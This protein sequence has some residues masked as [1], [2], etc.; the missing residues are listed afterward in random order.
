[1]IEVKKITAIETYDIRL[2]V[3]RKNIP[4]PFEFKGD[5]DDDTFH[6]GAF[7]N[8]KLISKT[9]NSYENS[10]LVNAKLL[11]K[12]KNY[13]MKY[14]Y[15]DQDKLTKT[16]FYKKGKLKESWIYECKPEGEKFNH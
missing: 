16:E 15:N 5:F 7:K 13:E 14:H 3:L 6:L 4:L 10:H 11:H 12:G 1:M 9:E 8:G 2:E